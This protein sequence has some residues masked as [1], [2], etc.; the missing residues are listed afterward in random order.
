MKF[1]ANAGDDAWDANSYLNI[2]VCNLGV[3]LATTTKF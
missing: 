1:S 2:Q 3:V